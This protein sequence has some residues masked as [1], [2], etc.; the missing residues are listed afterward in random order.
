MGH[1]CQTK[2][3]PGK[4]VAATSFW[5]PPYCPGQRKSGSSRRWTILTTWPSTAISSA[6]VVLAYDEWTIISIMHANTWSS[7]V[8]CY[9]VHQ[10]LLGQLTTALHLGVEQ[11]C[12]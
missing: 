4:L 12:S 9:W 10:L 2:G 5:T 6:D 1:S 7:R 3:R 8:P 11:L